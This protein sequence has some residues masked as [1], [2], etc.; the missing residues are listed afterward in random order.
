MENQPTI[1]LC[2]EILTWKPERVCN[3]EDCNKGACYNYNGDKRRR[4]CFTHKLENMVNV[5]SKRCEHDGCDKIPTYNLEGEKTN[6]F[7]KEHKLPNMIDR[8]ALCETENCKI[9][10]H[11][12]IKG[13]IN[14]KFCVI[15]KSPN[16]VNVVTKTCEF[17]N[18]S[19]RN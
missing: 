13:N 16:M 5:A 17:E 4:F 11:Y 14:P 3:F 2:K 6:K 10:P 15:H 1:I 8:H 19:K 12:N 9:R 18:A 7:C